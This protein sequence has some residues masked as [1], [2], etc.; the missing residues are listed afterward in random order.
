MSDGDA[1]LRPA[2]AP[3]CQEISYFGIS[4]ARYLSPYSFEDRVHQHQDIKKT[5]S[6]THSCCIQII[7]PGSYR[8]GP[9]VGIAFCPFMLLAAACCRSVEASDDDVGTLP[10]KST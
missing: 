8:M 1:M 5:I 7:V 3:P 2:R 10:M 6:L 4:Q 9:S